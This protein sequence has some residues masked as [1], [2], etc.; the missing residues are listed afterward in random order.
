[1]AHIRL[2]RNIGAPIGRV[3]DV[4]TSPAN[5]TRYVTSLMDVRDLSPDAPKKGSTFKWEYKMFGVRFKGKGT[6]TDYV[7]N[8]GFGLALEGKFPIK[9]S[10]DFVDKG[11]STDLTVVVE[12]NVPGDFL[13]AM[14]NKLVIEKL[15]VLEAKNVLDKVKT[16]CEG[17]A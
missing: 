7:R 11:D 17:K 16:L 2:T 13:G 8:K 12:Y 10:Y 1:M 15:N 9:E 5:W 6:V 3:F 14:A 4:V